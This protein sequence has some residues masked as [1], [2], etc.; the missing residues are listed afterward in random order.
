MVYTCSR[1][2]VGVAAGSLGVS[3]CCIMAAECERYMTIIMKDEVI[4]I[5]ILSVCII[6]YPL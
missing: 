6:K 5:G 4:F 3:L 2:V 1:V